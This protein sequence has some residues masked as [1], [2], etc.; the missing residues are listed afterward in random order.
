MTATLPHR[1]L[2]RST[3]ELS[4]LKAYNKFGECDFLVNC[5]SLLHP[6]SETNFLDTWP[7]L[8]QCIIDKTKSLCK[9][10]SLL[11]FINK[12]SGKLELLW[13]FESCEDFDDETSIFT[14][15][16]VWF[17]GYDYRCNFV[18]YYEIGPIFPQFGLI[19]EL[20]VLEDNSSLILINP[21]KVQ[22]FCLETFAYKIAP[23]QET[24]KL[25]N[26]SSLVIHDAVEI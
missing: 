10:P 12:E 8:S 26:I 24:F 19:S 17:G 6:D 21:S 3:N 15:N 23:V 14:T 4:I 7:S 2:L 20:I 5:P 13:G 22:Y 18:V 25:I 9:P 11:K 16:Q 1:N